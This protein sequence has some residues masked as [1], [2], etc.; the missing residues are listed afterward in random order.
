MSLIDFLMVLSNNKNKNVTYMPIGLVQ[1]VDG[2]NQ[3][4]HEFER[5]N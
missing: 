5:R 3:E 1:L 2:S 4:G